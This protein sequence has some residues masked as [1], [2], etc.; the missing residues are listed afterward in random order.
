MDLIFSFCTCQVD[1]NFKIIDDRKIIAK[2]YFKGWFLVDFIAI[3]QFD[4]IIKNVSE[5]AS[6]KA[7]G[8]GIIRVTKIGR[9][10]KL[11]KLT[12]LLRVL[13]VVKN[14]NTVLKYV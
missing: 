12:R 3:I 11:V 13:K 9:M 8:N 2:E 7:I 10:Y 1:E 6:N 5:S 14:K 4:T